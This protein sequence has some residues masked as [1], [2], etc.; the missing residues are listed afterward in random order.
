MDGKQ[1]AQTAKRLR[2]DLSVLLTSGYEDTPELV[3]QI[4]PDPFELLRKP[5]RREQL[6]AAVRRSL[7]PGDTG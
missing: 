5:Y 2:P 1:L 6:A 7:V 4:S 3:A